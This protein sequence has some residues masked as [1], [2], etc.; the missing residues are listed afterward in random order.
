MNNLTNFQEY[1]FLLHRHLNFIRRRK[2]WKIN[3]NVKNQIFPLII[4]KFSYFLLW[5]A[6]V[7]F[8]DPQKLFLYGFC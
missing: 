8:E 5:R 4:A 7:T 3:G 1:T 2:C 6:L